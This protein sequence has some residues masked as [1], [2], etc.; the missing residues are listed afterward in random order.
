MRS[1]QLPRGLAVAVN[2][3]FAIAQVEDVLEL[4]LPDGVVHLLELFEVVLDH[5]FFVFLVQQLELTLLVVRNFD[6]CLVQSGLVGPVF[7]C[8]RTIG[9]STCKILLLVLNNFVKDSLVFL[10]KHFKRTLHER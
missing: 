10:L 3:K 1:Q 7:C 8:E 4:V 2:S 9:K 5:A 6:D